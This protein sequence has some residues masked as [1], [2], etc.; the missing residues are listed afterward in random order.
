MTHLSNCIFCICRFMVCV[1]WCGW[2][3]QFLVRV[4]VFVF[5]SV[6]IFYQVE[7][8]L[9]KTFDCETCFCPGDIWRQTLSHL[10][11]Q[12]GGGTECF[13]PHIWIFIVYLCWGFFFNRSPNKWEASSVSFAPSVVTKIFHVRSVKLEL[14][15]LHIFFFFPLERFYKLNHFLPF[16]FFQ[17]RNKRN[18]SVSTL[19]SI[20]CSSHYPQCTPAYRLLMCLRWGV[21][22]LSM[23]LTDERATRWLF[24]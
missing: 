11:S 15:F 17:W 7:L 1:C 10:F 23:K 16:F 9:F 3:V 6:K 19:S 20:A 14:P 8:Y 18:C 12:G 21:Q 4:H 2:V 22:T 13:N 5:F 24:I